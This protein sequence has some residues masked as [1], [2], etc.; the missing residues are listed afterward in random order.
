MAK[1]SSFLLGTIVGGIAGAAATLFLSSERGKQL[2]QEFTET[3]MKR[4]QQHEKE[5]VTHDVEQQKE[6]EEQKPFSSIPIPLPS[7]DVEQL[8]KETEQ[9]VNDVEKRF[10]KGM[11]AHGEN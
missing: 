1:N 7:S 8:L 5:N 9:A 10:N 3:N 11:D 2:L 6:K 4:W